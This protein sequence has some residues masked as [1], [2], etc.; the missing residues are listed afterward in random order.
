[1]S[2][3][4]YS[5][6]HST[7]SPRSHG[8][9]AEQP[10]EGATHPNRRWNLASMTEELRG[11]G[12]VEVLQSHLELEGKPG[13]LVTLLYCPN[14]IDAVLFQQT[15]LREL[16]QKGGRLEA[17]WDSELLHFQE[18]KDNTDLYEA[19]FSGT[20][21]I[22]V[23]EG[24]EEMLYLY[25]IAD[26]PVRQPDES[27]MEVS[28]KGPRDG[29]VED[30]NQ[31]VCLVRRRLKTPDLQVEM[32]TLGSQSRT[33]VALLYM[34][35]LAKPD[36]VE[37][38]RTRLQDIRSNVVS[39]ESSTQIE[40]LISDVKGSIFPLVHYS[41]RPDFAASALMSGRI[42]ILVDGNPAVIAA[43]ANLAFLIKSPE[44][45]SM[46]FFYVSLERTLRFIGL[47]MSIF[48]PGFWIALC[49]FN[50]D[51]IPFTLLAT[52]STSRNGLPLS[53]TMEMFL[54]LAMFELFR[55]AGVR[56]PRAVGQTVSV[57]GGLIVGNAA[58][59]AGLTSPTMLVVAAIT[60]VSTFTLVNQT[61]NGTVS[62]LRFFVLTCSAVLGMFGFFAGMFLIII[63][64]CS[65]ETFGQPYMA[66]LANMDFKLM[67]PS[68]LQVPWKRRR[69]KGG[70]KSHD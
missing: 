40:S 27:V 11:C 5:G 69:Q 37:M 23:G 53:S 8:N 47:F 39:I 63:H 18:Y 33:Q 45:L 38:A 31:N 19:L 26:M 15:V 1:M 28:L 44:D 56:L 41:G 3:K 24:R 32:M 29:F 14:M 59:D 64:V 35:S 65:L 54:M 50:T 9:E 58:I 6:K 67:L 17:G 52:V 12:D 13:T 34:A 55:E 21:I 36:V 25:N 16:R 7:N 51:Q 22:G 10:N 4:G 49:S 48:L 20:V 66:P 43:P 30:V 68:F 57:V 42:A 61:L 60:A 70:G 46:P 2:Q 62:V